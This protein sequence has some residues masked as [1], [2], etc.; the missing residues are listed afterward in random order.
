MSRFVQHEDFGI[1][2]VVS[3]LGRIRVRFE[4]GVTESFPLGSH[5]IAFVTFIYPLRNRT[6]KITAGAC[7]GC[8]EESALVG[9][10]RAGSRKGVALCAE[11]EDASLNA[12][13]LPDDIMDSGRVVAGSLG[14][15]KRR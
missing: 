3:D 7:D 8:G 13:G 1:G 14:S 2:T 10:T 5:E 4:S 11:C 15:G 12:D 6:N 9:W